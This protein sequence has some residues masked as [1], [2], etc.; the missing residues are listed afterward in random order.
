[1]GGNPDEGREIAVES[2]DEKDKKSVYFNTCTPL[3]H[4]AS[5]HANM[6][7]S[8]LYREL[9]RLEDEATLLREKGECWQQ[10]EAAS[11]R[12]VSKGKK[13]SW[14]RRNKGSEGKQKRNEWV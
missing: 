12:K 5:F 11:R 8:E 9:W 4:S 3:Q 7:E 2:T 1:M 13:G 14:K 10:A 6:Q